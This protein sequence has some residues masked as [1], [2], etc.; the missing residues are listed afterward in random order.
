MEAELDR[1]TFI[2]RKSFRAIY[3]KPTDVSALPRVICDSVEVTQGLASGD[4]RLVLESG[5]S[6]LERV[7][8]LNSRSR[9]RPSFRCLTAGLLVC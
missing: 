1:G 8:C 2:Y 6:R 9:E 4:E 5:R 3:W 7:C